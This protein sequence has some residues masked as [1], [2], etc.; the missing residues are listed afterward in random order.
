MIAEKEFQ[1]EFRSPESRRV[2]PGGAEAE[3]ST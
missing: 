2:A 3:A 1:K